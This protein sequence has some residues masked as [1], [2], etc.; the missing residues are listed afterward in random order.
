[1][2]GPTIRAHL[3]LRALVSPS[4][5]ARAYSQGTGS[6]ANKASRTSPG[7]TPVK[8]ESRDHP[9]YTSYETPVTSADPSEMPGAPAGSKPASQTSGASTTSGT[10]HPEVHTMAKGA[11]SDQGGSGAVSPQDRTQKTWG[12]NATPAEFNRSEGRRKPILDG[13][14]HEGGLREDGK[15]SKT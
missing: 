12:A 15:G 9:G 6:S 7:A 11:E 8:G 10:P 14:S 5:V 2:L 4:R 1:M 13:G 3:S